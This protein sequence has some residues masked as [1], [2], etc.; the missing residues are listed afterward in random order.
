M[1]SSPSPLSRAS[2]GGKSGCGARYSEGTSLLE[3][4]MRNRDS[5]IGDIRRPGVPLPAPLQADLAS[6]LAECLV[7]ELREDNVARGQKVEKPTVESPRGTDRETR[8]VAEDKGRA[9][10][11][12]RTL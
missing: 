2:K 1:S 6:I 3:Q 9:S 10:W 8:N 4:R 7:A 5:H 12:G 11:R